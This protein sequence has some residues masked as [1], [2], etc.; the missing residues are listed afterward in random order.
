MKS[1]ERHTSPQPII[2]NRILFKFSSFRARQEHISTVTVVFP[3]KRQEKR[4]WKLETWCFFSQFAL[5]AAAVFVVV[6]VVPTFHHIFDGI[7]W[8]HQLFRQDQEEPIE[9]VLIKLKIATSWTMMIENAVEDRSRITRTDADT[10]TLTMNGERHTYYTDTGTFFVFFLAIE[11]QVQQVVP[12]VCRLFFYTHRHLHTHTRAQAQA[13][14]QDARKIS[15]RRRWLLY[16]FCYAFL[17]QYPS[18]RCGIRVQ[19]ESKRCICKDFDL[20]SQCTGILSIYMYI[21]MYI[22][23]EHARALELDQQHTHIRCMHS[24]LLCFAAHRVAAAPSSIAGSS[25][26]S[27]SFI[28]FSMFLIN[29]HIMLWIDMD[30]ASPNRKI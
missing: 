20:E 5:A 21:Y 23:D 25:R 19:T 4:I 10:S 30:L 6:V 15:K 22:I 28:V 29:E 7:V 18:T 17:V 13:Q 24:M 12:L 26:T 14:A 27:G 2:Q 11:R 16:C 9:M 3:D 1:I 8:S